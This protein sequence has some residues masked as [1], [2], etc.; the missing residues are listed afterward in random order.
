MRADEPQFVPHFV[1]TLITKRDDIAVCDLWSARFEVHAARILDGLIEPCS[2]GGV[3]VADLMSV[4]AMPV[5]GE[6]LK[7]MTGLTNI[8]S[9]DMDGWSQAIID[10]ISNYTGDPDREAHCR[11]ATAAI[12]VAI[13]VAIDEMLPSARRSPGN[14][15][16]SV[17]AESGMPLEQAPANIKL[18]IAGGQNEPR[19][20]IAGAGRPGCWWGGCW[21]GDV[22]IGV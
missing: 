16:L 1:G 20:A 7:S 10:G 19:D 4:Y 3:E 15:L 2:V 22:A 12:D 18:T 21:W 9:A 6:A 8:T 14:D 13:D 17:M 11:D 5:S